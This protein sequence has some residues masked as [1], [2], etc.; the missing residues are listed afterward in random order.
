[1]ASEQDI[2][3]WTDLLQQAAP[4]AQFPL[5]QGIKQWLC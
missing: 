3:N 1:M 2:S 4:S 5:L